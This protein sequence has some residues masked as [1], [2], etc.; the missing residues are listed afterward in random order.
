M[1]VQRLL[2]ILRLQTGYLVPGKKCA[3][4]LRNPDPP[5]PEQKCHQMG[6]HKRFWDILGGVLRRISPRIFLEGSRP[7]NLNLFNHQKLQKSNE[8]VNFWGKLPPEATAGH[9]SGLGSIPACPGCLWHAQDASG[10]PSG[11]HNPSKNLKI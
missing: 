1:P 3:S 8:N 5:N 11:P 7:L 9:R 10:M 2:R 4:W 6:R